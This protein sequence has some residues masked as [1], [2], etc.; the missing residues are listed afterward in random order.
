MTLIAGNSAF[1][2]NRSISVPCWPCGSGN[3]DA[4][5]YGF[6]R[7][8]RFRRR[9]IHAKIAA[10]AMTTTVATTLI[11]TMAPVERLCDGADDG[12]GL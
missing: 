8:R 10:A 6:K 7:R 12:V 5:V 4:G 2:S 9:K 1:G 3:L 11:V